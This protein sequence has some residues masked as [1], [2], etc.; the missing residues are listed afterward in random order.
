ML[1]ISARENRLEI[2]DVADFRLHFRCVD[3]DAVRG[4]GGARL[5]GVLL[6]TPTYS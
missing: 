3:V 1:P 2:D 4:W 6:Y 5:V